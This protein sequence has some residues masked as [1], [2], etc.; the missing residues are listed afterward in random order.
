MVF[1]MEELL[2][3]GFTQTRTDLVGFAP[4]KGHLS[5]ACPS[6]ETRLWEL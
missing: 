6:S 5:P 3:V 4:G 1:R 2:G